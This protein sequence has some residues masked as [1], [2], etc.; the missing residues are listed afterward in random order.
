MVPPQVPTLIAVLVDPPRIPKRN[1][2]ST[3]VTGAERRA[4]LGAGGRP[5]CGA[6]RGQGRDL[7]TGFSAIA[8][9]TVVRAVPADVGE[10]IV[11]FSKGA[12]VG[13][14]FH[15]PA[16]LSRG[17]LSAGDVVNPVPRAWDIVGYATGARRPLGVGR[18]AWTGSI[19]TTKPRRS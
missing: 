16:E 4:G 18:P 10:T 13:C 5:G 1:P 11:N 3:R 19:M 7:Q 17:R 14:G 8:C 9:G 2:K 6:R 12:L 15:A